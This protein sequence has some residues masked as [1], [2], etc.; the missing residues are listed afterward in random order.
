MKPNVLSIRINV[1]LPNNP[2]GSTVKI[3]C[4]H[5]NIPYDRYWRRRLDDSKIDN[6]IEIKEDP[7]KPAVEISKKTKAPEEKI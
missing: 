5:N 2:K 7:I 6:C 4:D 3:P 1:D